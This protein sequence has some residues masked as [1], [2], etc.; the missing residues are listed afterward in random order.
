M[1]ACLFGWTIILLL[2]CTRVNHEAY[3]KSYGLNCCLT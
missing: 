2:L 1:A 3:L